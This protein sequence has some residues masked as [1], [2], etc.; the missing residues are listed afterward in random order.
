MEEKLIYDSAEELSQVL[1][2]Q[3]EQPV[4]N[5]QPVVDQQPTEQVSGEQ[6]QLE[7]V[8]SSEPVVESQPEQTNLESVVDNQQEEEFEVVDLSGNTQDNNE[9]PLSQY[10]QQDID[11]AIT[12][13]LSDKLGRDISSLDELQSPQ[14]D[15]RVLAIAKFVEETGRGPED[16]FRYQ[17]LDTNGMDDLT[18]VRVQMA[19]DY[20][21]LSYDE[22]NTLLANNYKLDPDKFD[23][24]TVR[25]SALQLKIDGQKAK[26][27][28]EGY[29]SSYK[30]PE[31]AQQLEQTQ[32][33]FIDENWINEMSME[34]DAMNS[35]EFDLGNESTFKFQLNDDYKGQ[36]KQANAN[37]ENYFNS[38]VRND[39]SWNY[40]LLSAHRAIIDN[41]DSIVKSSY[42]QGLGDG[43]KNI[44]EKAANVSTKSPSQ[45]SVQSDVDPVVEQIK[46]I[47]G[48]QTT[49]F[50]NFK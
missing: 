33:S 30:A 2:Q 9:D 40:D 28:I 16:W 38:Y 35:L 14:V 20:P 48:S 4:A 49:T 17:S 21:N 31:V 41:I 8:Q 11:Q 45:Q 18:A 22:I 50:M 37:L 3:Q 36:L 5:E 24:D 1:S 10:N 29:R 46:N 15:E 47:M 6:P 7:T 32:Q 13:Y 42:Q 39:G 44:V 43:Q 26:Q 19:T 34:V 23:D 12:K 27:S 25:L